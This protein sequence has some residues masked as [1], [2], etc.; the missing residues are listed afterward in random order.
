VT[1]DVDVARRPG[2][3]SRARG[4][5][6]AMA[7]VLAVGSALLYARVGHHPF[8]HF[9]DNRY[10][11]EN[12]FVQRGLS[13]ANVAWAFSTLT[14]S[15]WHPLTWLSHM[16][17]VQLFGLDAGAHHLVN[18]A[19]HAANAVVLFLVLA[20]MTLAPGRSA[21]VAALF[22]VHPTHVESVA[23]VAERKDLLSSLL[24]LLA[25]AAYARYVRRPA[26]GRYALVVAA[27]AA[28]LLAKPMWVTLPFLLLLLDAWPLG[29]WRSVGARRLVL[30]KLPLLALSAASS[31][32]TVVAQDRGGAITGL[33]LPVSLRLGNAAVS[34]VRYAAKTF[35]P[36][37]LS[38]YYPHPGSELSPLLAIAA[39]LVCVGVTAST[40]AW[41][42]RAPW[43]AVGWCWFLGTLVPVIG[44]VQAGGQAMADRYTYLP[45]I[46]LLLA[47]VWSAER[48]AARFSATLAGVAV[49]A[50]LT[51]ALA[52]VT[53][54][55]L[56]LWANHVGLFQHALEVGGESGVV[57]GVLSEG[58]RHE[59]RVAEAL[60]QART[61][62][63]FD[64]RSA[65]HRINLGNMYRE[66]GRLTEARE[67]LEQAVSLDPRHP[68]AWTNLGLVEQDARAYVDAERAFFQVTR[69]TPGDAQAWSRLGGLRARTFRPLEAIEAFREAVRLDAG[70]AA[71]WANLAVAYQGVGRVQEAHA[72]FETV[73]RVDP[74]NYVAW[75]NLGVFLAKFGRPAEA[76]PAFERALQLR[77]GDGELLHRLA[78][79]QLAAGHRDA[80]LATAAQLE[81]TDAARAAD[82]RSKAGG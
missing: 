63:Q 19:L 44:L 76:A 39:A 31:A 80:A 47:A 20:R 22:A 70:Y 42:R 9:D 4:F 54:S 82:V 7:T 41:A 60:E 71:A 33:D 51:L 13:W 73:T 18:V 15:N 59:G 57:H 55:Y 37:P 24:G 43:A 52:G 69:L 34:Y 45:T 32:V 21:V 3:L 79:S 17:D 2:A 68:G 35:W 28:S 56:E 16:L 6:P 78:L 58:L 14:A 26:L 53:L 62:V 49:A 67:Q 25:L 11:T 8:L 75:R 5:V 77:P 65:R 81:R 48:V 61:A 30:E 36:H 74:A 46:G 38:I 12:P 66:A 64:P 29:R 72:A 27:F 50:M 40:V 23:W 1:G 10:V